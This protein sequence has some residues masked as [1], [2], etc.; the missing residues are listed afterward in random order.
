MRDPMTDAIN[1]PYLTGQLDL[2]LERDPTTDAITSFR[3]SPEFYEPD[4]TTLAWR[5]EYPDDIKNEYWKDLINV[6]IND[7]IEK[8]SEK[9]RNSFTYSRKNLN[10]RYDWDKVEKKLFH[11]YDGLNDDED[12]ARLEDAVL[13]AFDGSILL[14]LN[15]HMKE[16]LL[17]TLG[18][19]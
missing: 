7:F 6:V 8:M 12:G 11:L 18:N 17:S 13:E 9:F 2:K 5:R 15:L 3:F 19:A 14:G 1:L 4:V 10:E 16:D